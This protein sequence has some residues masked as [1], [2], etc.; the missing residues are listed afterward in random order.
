MKTDVHKILLDEQKKKFSQELG[1]TSDWLI[2]GFLIVLLLRAMMRTLFYDPPWANAQ[3][4]GF[5]SLVIWIT[6]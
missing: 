5:S 3:Q 4:N 6:E 2:C 1:D